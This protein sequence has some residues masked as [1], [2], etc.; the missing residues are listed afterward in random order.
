MTHS[1]RAKQN[2]VSVLALLLCAGLAGCAGSVG[3]NAGAGGGGGSNPNGATVPAVP[4]GLMATAGNAQVTLSWNASATATSYNVKRGTTSGGPYTKISSPTATSF[5]DTSLT[6]GTTYFYVV[7]AVNATGESANSSE[8]NAKPVAPAQAPAAPTGLIA[9]AGNAQVSLSWSASA[10]ATSYNV[11]RSATSGGP[12]TKISSPTTTNFTDMGLANGTTYFYVVSAVNSTG[13]S[14]NSAQVSATPSAPAQTPAVPTGIQAT[15]GNTQV[16]LSW[17]VTSGATSYHVKRSTTN[18]GPYTQIAAPT[19]TSFTDTGLIN[20]TTYFYVVSALNSVGESA[21]SAQV[22]ATPTAP[23]AVDVTITI[24]PTKTKPISPYIYGTNFYFGNTDPS[25]LLTMDRD[26]GNRWTAYNWETNASNAGSDYLYENDN[27]LSSSTVPAEAVRSFIAA[28]Q[29]SGLASLV[30]VQLQGLVSAD[31]SGPVSISNPPD[32]TRFKTV[33][34]KKSAVS[35]TPFTTTPVTTDANV[36]MD[37]FVWA[38]DQKLPGI[39]GTNPAHPTFISLDNEPELWNSTHLEVQGHNRVTSDNYI[40]KTI[41]LSKAIKDQFPTALIFGPVHY[42]FQG[43][44]NWQGELSAT[45]SGTNWFPD[46]YLQAIK[47]AST[48]YGKPLVDVYDFHWYAEDYD[49]NGTRILDLN[50]TTLTD[51]QVQLIVQSPRN[52]WDPTFTDSGNSNPWIFQELG[53]TPINILGRLQAKINAENPGMKIAITEYESGGWNHIAGTI[54][55]TDNLGI[56][57]AQGVFAASF[58]PPNGTYSYALAGFRA[59]RGFDGANASF[60]DTSLQASSSNVQ[61]VVVYAG[62]D[63]GTPGRIVFVAINRSTSAKVTAITGQSLSG[64]AHLYQMTAASAATQVSGGMP[65]QPVSAGTMPASGSTLT[66]TLPAL[67]V[68]TIDVH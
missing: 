61:N 68:T 32:L 41:N 27:Y 53:S 22:S 63:S 16:I 50:G 51:A 4:S 40:T 48:A 66:L 47:T 8:A 13:E 45:P 44:Y 23:S 19:A 21:N 64:T 39:F 18:G 14:A 7:S 9:T 65:V 10:T 56:F 31:E 24:D 26:G 20:D 30:T 25:P 62:A 33:V 34:D 28:D 49:A 6:D 46:K 60:G 59:F 11:K 42:G 5:I 43:I 37:E 2:A 35:A 17:A 29:S 12:Y 3:G 54:A 55:Q 1:L 52:L 67:S 57:G 58:W 38:L 15:P 36:Y